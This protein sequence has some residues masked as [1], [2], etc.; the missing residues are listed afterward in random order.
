MTARELRDK[1]CQSVN[2]NIDSIII[3]SGRQ[4]DT[5]STVEASANDDGLIDYCY[6]E[7]CAHLSPEMPA[8]KAEQILETLDMARKV[9][10]GK[11]K[12]RIWEQA[13]REELEA[14][15]AL[16]LWWND[17]LPDVSGMAD[18]FKEKN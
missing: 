11:L 17:V 6:L 13:M 8:E 7:R 10:S 1:K 12:G 18:P 9:K 3:I 4:F 16:I 15:D 2:K 14:L 5:F